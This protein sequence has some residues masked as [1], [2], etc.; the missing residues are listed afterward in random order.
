MDVFAW[1]VV[2]SVA[3][4]A[5]VVAAIVFGA[6]P[7]VRDRRKA[8]APPTGQRPWVE[9]PDGRGVQ[10]GERNERVNQ[11]IQTYIEYR[12]P[13]AGPVTGPVVA[14][15]VPRQPP[16]FQPRHELMAALA[17]SGPGVAV[18]RAV[19][20]MRGV[21]KT[22]VA[23]AYARACIDA[24]WRLVAWANA[25]DMA[26]VLNGLAEIGAGLGV[27]GP[28]PDLES[29][30][31]A[32]RHRLEADGQR[33]LVVFDN[34]TD[35]DGLARFVPAAGQCQVIITSNQLESSNLGAA[36][37]VGVF[38]EE[39]AL[40]FLAQRTGRSDAGRAGE[41]AAE[42]G[43]LPLALA[44]AAAVIAA[45]HLDYPAYLARLRA[46]P[47]QELLKRAAGE[48]YPHGAA[49]AIVLA[50]EAAADGDTTGLCPGLV[51]VVA[52]LS[53]AGVS[54]ALLYA[55][56]QQGL[57]GN[58]SAS[59]PAGPEVIDQALG[60]LASASLLTFSVDDA[61]VT[62]H[63]L[64]MRV[65]RERQ[66]HDR[67]LTGLGT[68]V[69]GL[70]EMVT[71]SMGEPW[72][73]LA[74]ARDLIQQIMALH[75]HLAPHL[76]GQGAVL[77]ETLLS[78]RGWAVWCLNELGDSFAQAIDYGQDLV[79]DC[80]RILGESH[81]ET[82]ASRKNLAIAYHAAGRL[83]E[84]IPLLERTLADCDRALDDTHP[85]TIICRN[86]LAQAYEQT[87]RP[88]EA[89][90]LLERTLADCERV[91]GGTHL[92]TLAAR[93]NLALT[94]RKAGR[95]QIEEVILSLERNLAEYGQVV[96]E[97]HP[98]A[99]ATRNSLGL[100]YRE[101][102]RLEEA[103]PLLE[104][105]V[106]DRERVLGESDR[107]TLVSRNN[108]ANA[109]RE[110]GRPDEAIPL[111]ERNLADCERVFGRIHPYTLG[112]RHSLA[113]A[114]QAAGRLEEAIPLLERTLADYKHIMGISHLYTM[115]CRDDLA[116]AYKAA[117]RLDD[118]E[119]MRRAS[120]KN[121]S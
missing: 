70:L 115:T 68:G 12:Q 36:V 101:A 66:V 28:G 25:A 59:A 34:A 31:V 35:I 56:G 42:L 109:Y 6:I 60:R 76:S 112:S 103:I 97:T 53:P 81:P 11:Y 63:R 61:T 73:N 108:L 105:T 40:A 106:T 51:N 50:L 2:G 1:T 116:S 119:T 93:S 71:Q 110:A 96:G 8:T 24:G 88:E 14:G 9:V 21:G 5:G 98:A 47:V 94:H 3:G 38:T 121:G 83:E 80:E 79:A 78:L 44:Q 33:C 46:A 77:A 19:T 120:T 102:G 16:A 82:L 55:A 111:S 10:I 117:G 99:L 100:I 13:L 92:A 52:L 49:E 118:A 75:N 90:A 74:A 30:A 45:R 41:L 43:Y 18:V 91:L 22:Q 17:A 69:A 85:D 15:E 64:T 89:I 114:Y 37:P 107:D 32:V 23:A 67:S 62:A 84:A 87:G 48:P 26:S 57:F 95:I 4:V 39:E 20:G 27:A 65:T 113:L 104:R 7:L 86:V 29:V 72:R 54:R 58:P